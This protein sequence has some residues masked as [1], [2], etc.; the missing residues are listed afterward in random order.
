MSGAAKNEQ[1]TTA[2]IGKAAQLVV[3][4]V[5]SDVRTAGHV[6]LPEDPTGN[7]RR[8][9]GSRIGCFAG[10]VGCCGAHLA[11]FVSCRSWLTAAVGV[12]PLIAADRLGPPGDGHRVEA[13]IVPP[14]DGGR[15]RPGPAEVVV[16]VG[17]RFGFR[18]F[19]SP[20]KTGPGSAPFGPAGSALSLR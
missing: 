20:F 11:G 7:G 6:S 15:E 9:S 3:S 17:V 10:G 12:S 19:W 18:Q 2:E 13:H 8:P 5:L 4:R 16:A 1:V 14:A